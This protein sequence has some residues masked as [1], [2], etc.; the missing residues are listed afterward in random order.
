MNE[1]IQVEC[2]DSEPMII[3][4]LLHIC[5]HQNGVFLQWRGQFWPLQIVV[6]TIG[7]SLEAFSSRLSEIAIA[8]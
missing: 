4:G 1:C 2:D 3:D 5:N 6:N 8:E 7:H